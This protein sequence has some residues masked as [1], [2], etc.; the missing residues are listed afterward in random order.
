MHIIQNVRFKYTNTC[1][2]QMEIGEITKKNLLPLHKSK[3]PC[4]RAEISYTEMKEKQC[5]LTCTHQNKPLDGITHI[6][7]IITGYRDGYSQSWPAK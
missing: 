6:I 7:N 4:G 3:Q 5:G 2:G 1:V